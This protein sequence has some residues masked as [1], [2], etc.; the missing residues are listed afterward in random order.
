MFNFSNKVGYLNEA[1]IPVNNI[2]E[3]DEHLQNA[4]VS[5]TRSRE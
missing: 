3:W 4:L 2:P 1:T 5:N